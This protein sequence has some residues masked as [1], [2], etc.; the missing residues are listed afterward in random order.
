MRD[1]LGLLFVISVIVAIYLIWQALRE[2]L[3]AVLGVFI[4]V[5]LYYAVTS[6]DDKNK[7]P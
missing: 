3:I 2:V 4:A 7:K 5:L 6:G 1:F